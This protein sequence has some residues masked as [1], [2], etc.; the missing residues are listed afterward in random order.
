MSSVRNFSRSIHTVPQE[1]LPVSLR[2]SSSH[3]CSD[4]SST[5]C[6]PMTH[7]PP[8]G[9]I[10]KTFCD[11][12]IHPD[13]TRRYNLFDIALDSKPGTRSGFQLPSSLGYHSRFRASPSAASSKAPAQ[14]QNRTMQK[15]RSFLYRIRSK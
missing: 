14:G 10:K 6:S 13:T 9:A 15:A 3:R 1:P 7:P 11:C 8:C 4:A 2:A 5:P 12:H